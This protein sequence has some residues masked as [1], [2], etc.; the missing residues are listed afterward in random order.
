[1]SKYGVENYTFLKKGSDNRLSLCRSYPTTLPITIIYIYIKH[2]F[3]N[4]DDYYIE[5]T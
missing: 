1:L 5:I 3:T 2:V 4:N